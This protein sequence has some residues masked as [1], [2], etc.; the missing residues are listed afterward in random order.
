MTPFVICDTTLSSLIC[1]PT[2]V[3][4]KEMVFSA[5]FLA[6]TVSSAFKPF[7]SPESEWL[8]QCNQ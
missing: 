1:Y 5:E 2:Q 4:D 6:A 8:L 3:E 7:P